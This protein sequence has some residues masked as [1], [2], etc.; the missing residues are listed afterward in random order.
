MRTKDNNVLIAY[1]DFLIYLS[2][3]KGTE[4]AKGHDKL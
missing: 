4:P 3:V 1:C 2:H